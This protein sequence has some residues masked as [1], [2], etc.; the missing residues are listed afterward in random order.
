MQVTSDML[1]ELIKTASDTIA[2]HD[3]EVT[4]LDKTL[5]DGDHV[6]NIRRGLGFLVEQSEELS[7]LEWPEAWKKMGMTCMSKIGGA[8]GSL[9]GTFFVAMGKDSAGKAVDPVVFA[10]AYN[11][12]VEAMKARGKSDAGEKTM[13]DTLIPVANYFNENCGKLEYPELLKGLKETAI[14][15]MESTKA[16]HATK[17]RSSFLGERSVGHIDAGAR[18]IQ[19]MICAI[20]DAIEAK[21]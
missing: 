7:Q 11:A 3:A 4:E 12:A 1:A 8:S 19:L 18:S 13:L 2:E 15:G 21:L 20:A 9:I 16:M 6:I 10:S 5:G 17:G 14:K